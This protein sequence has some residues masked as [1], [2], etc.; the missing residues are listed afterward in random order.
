[1]YCNF[2]RCVAAIFALSILVVVPVAA[3]PSKFSDGDLAKARTFIETKMEPGARAALQELA[4][5]QSLSPEELFLRIRAGSAQDKTLGGGSDQ[6][7][8][9]EK[10]DGSDSGGGDNSPVKKSD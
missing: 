5:K 7:N 3:E 2:S 4:A 8:I 6:D 9:P 10:R 1:M